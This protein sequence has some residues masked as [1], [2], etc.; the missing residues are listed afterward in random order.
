MLSYAG[1]GEGIYLTDEYFVLLSN[2]S[3]FWIPVAG[4]IYQY[5]RVCVRSAVRTVSEIYRQEKA[6]KVRC[7]YAVDNAG[8]NPRL[9]EPFLAARLSKG[10]GRLNWLPPLHR[11]ML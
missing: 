3:V 6:T 5:A 9:P 7:T 11:F 2:I 1:E 10:V 4:M 8:F